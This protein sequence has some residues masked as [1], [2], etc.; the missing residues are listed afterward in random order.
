MDA[1]GSRIPK[2]AALSVVVALSAAFLL[3]RAAAWRT[4]E[5]LIVHPP[6]QPPA[7]A[8]RAHALGPLDGVPPALRAALEDRSAFEPIAKPGSADWLAAQHEA[9]QTFPQFVASRPN[10]PVGAPSVGRS[11]SLA[12]ARQVL[13]L[14]PLGAFAGTEAPPVDVL[15]RFAEAF[16]TTPVKALPQ[17]EVEGLG[18]TDRINRDTRVRQ[19][20]TADLLRFLRE[21]I[22]ADAFAVLGLTV[23]DLYPGPTWNYVFGQASL[24]DRVGIYS[25]ARYAPTT[26]GKPAPAQLI[27]LR[28]CKVLAH[29]GSHMF[30]L[31]HCIYYRCLMNGSNHLGE[32]DARPLHLCP[33]CLRKLQW[34]AGF[35]VQ[36]RYQRLAAVVRELGFEDEEAWLAARVPAGR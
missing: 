20:L 34:S 17:K 36:D 13:Y 15:A 28:G 3:D 5:Q 19:L 26:S 8:Q 16:F 23:E 27:L 6:F 25:F 14:Q 24:T 31:E 32:L 30:G 12:G 7:A 35:D 9:G 11:R 29:E 22:P 10:R 33:V 4:E 21:R 1:E 18:V 2:I